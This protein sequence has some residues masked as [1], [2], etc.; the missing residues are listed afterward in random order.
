M[1]NRFE[2][3]LSPQDEQAVRRF[4]ARLAEQPAGEP[5]R[6]TPD[7]LWWKARLLRR[8]DAERRVSL[9]LDVMEPFQIVAGLAAAATIALWALPSVAHVLALIRR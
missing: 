9:P 8:W 5:P 4:M 7:V 3:D 6:L 1:L 2:P